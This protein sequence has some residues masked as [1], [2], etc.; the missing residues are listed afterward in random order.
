[1]GYQLQ[2]NKD[3]TNEQVNLNDKLSSTLP[4]LL[5]RGSYTAIVTLLPPPSSPL[6]LPLL[7]HHTRPRTNLCENAG[8]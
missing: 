1:M 8:S 2:I 6:P 7:S 3:P 4:H 5:L